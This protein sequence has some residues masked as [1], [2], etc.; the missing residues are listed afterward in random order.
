MKRFATLLLLLD[1]ALFVPMR[2]LAATQVV[3]GI[4]WTYRV[5]GGKATIYKGYNQPAIPNSTSGG[6]TI[7]SKLGGYSVSS[8]G[9]YAFYGCSGM[10]SITIPNTVT[11]IGG[12]AFEGC[13]GLTSITIPNSVTS[14]GA[15][16][17]TSSGLSSVTIPN[18]VTSIEIGVFTDCSGLTSITIPN[19]VT[20]IRDG[21]FMGSGL[22]SITI[23][24]SVTSIGEDAFSY[25]HG[26]TSVT[27]P[28]G[29]MSIGKGAFYSCHGLTSVTISDSLVNIGD[30]PFSFCNNL[31]ETR[32]IISDLARWATNSINSNLGGTRRLFIGDVEISEAVIPDGV[33]TIANDAFRDCSGLISITIPNSVTSIGNN[34]FTGCTGLSEIMIPNGVTSIG[35]NAFSGCTGLT[36]ISIPNSM[37]SIGSNVFSGCAGTVVLLKANNLSPDVLSA[38]ALNQVRGVYCYRSERAAVIAA[39]GFEKLFG[40]FDENENPTVFQAEILSATIRDNDPNVM[41]VDYVVHSDSPMVN[42]RA[43]A[44]ENG[45]RGFA[46]ILRPKTFIEGTGANVGDGIAANV[47]HRLSWRIPSDWNTDY[48]KASFEVLAM[49]PGSL[50]LPMHFVTIPAAEGHPKTIV[51]VNDTLLN[52]AHRIINYDIENPIL[53]NALF[54]LYANPESDLSLSN[55]TLLA[56]NADLIH[57]ILFASG[58]Q[59]C[60][61]NAVGYVFGKMGYRLLADTEELDWINENT[62]LNIQPIIN[63]SLGSRYRL[64]RQYAVKTVEE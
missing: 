58:Q 36:E 15:F 10:T 57:D 40:C 24:N 18:S 55:G 17:F 6:V 38:A 39:I 20:S 34:A 12:D 5:S 45:V 37:T 9:D 41:D 46:T 29:V 43:L 50:L 14:I 61:L 49:E 16:A 59:D 2:L 53:L 51:S 52:A 48:G 27:I 8:I 44:F 42:V 56:N 28:N 23:P 31:T 60:V 4:E 32:I 25:C 47:A 26:L 35:N 21:A 13:S 1:V 64:F 19:S 3:N 22:T 54:W 30:N 7:P 63:S 33:T 11:S 62:R